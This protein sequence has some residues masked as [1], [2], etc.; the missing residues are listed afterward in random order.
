[1]SIVVELARRAEQGRPVRVGLIGC[2]EMGTDIVTQVSLM[3]GIELAVL[4]E[5]RVDMARSCSG[6][7]QAEDAI[8]AGKIA[9]TQDGTVACSAAQVDVIID[10][11]GNPGIGA[12]LALHA[13]RH[14]KHV[15]MMN[16]E[17]T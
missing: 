8:R 16:V 2:G 9:I 13:M 6:C 3:P 1:M 17:R 10:A 5:M 15:V 14:G 4:A 12:E 11:T 7:A